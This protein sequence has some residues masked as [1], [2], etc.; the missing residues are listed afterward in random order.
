MNFAQILYQEAMH[1]DLFMSLKRWFGDDVNE[2]RVHQVV[3]EELVKLEWTIDRDPCE[4]GTMLTEA[5]PDIVI[6][7]NSSSGIDLYSRFF[8]GAQLW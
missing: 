1:D 5:F 4:L 3:P 8:N 2:V 6:E 7:T